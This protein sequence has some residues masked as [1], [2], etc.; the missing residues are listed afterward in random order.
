LDDER[1][2]NYCLSH[3]LAN[4]HTLYPPTLCQNYD[5][6]ASTVGQLDTLLKLPQIG[7]VTSTSAAVG[8]KT[9]KL[10]QMAAHLKGS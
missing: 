2:R 1:V 6:T 7:Q 4:L 5:S 3:S 9:W 8:V 10:V